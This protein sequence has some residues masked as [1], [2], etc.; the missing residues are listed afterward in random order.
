M[1]FHV[2]ATDYD[3]TIARHGVV[4]RATRD[5]MERVRTSG[6]KVVLVTGR[7]LR[8]LERVFPEIEL[9]D[10][11]VAENGAV[12]HHPAK[13]QTR[14]LAEPPPE[15]FAATLR[16]RGVEPLSVGQV[17]VATWEPH[18]TV[19]LET[20]HALGLELQVIFNKGAVMVLPS[21]INKAVGLR[22]ALEDLRLSPH[23]AVAIGD[24]END[25]AFLAVSE[26]AVVVANALP[27]LK[28]RADHVTAG[29]HGEG[30]AEL[31]DAMVADD[32]TAI[33]GRLA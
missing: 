11:I 1:R 32:L 28:E 31:A 3:G 10:A 24:A 16:E 19:V 9:F 4:D 14:L 2:L 7:E 23:N 13:K 18:E 20:I 6:R 33:A 30:V 8:D 15:T 12:I 21:G 27:A 26:C 29:D 5:A 22:A 17:I 25:H